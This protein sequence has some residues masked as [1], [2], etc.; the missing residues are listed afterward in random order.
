MLIDEFWTYEGGNAKDIDA[1][2]KRA[3][4][5][6]ANNDYDSEIESI[7]IM[8]Q[9]G[10]VSYKTNYFET[11][12]KM[13]M[14]AF[15]LLKEAKN[16]TLSYVEITVLAKLNEYAPTFEVLK[17][18]EKIV[19]ELLETRYKHEEKHNNV[20]WMVSG[21]ILPRLIKAKFS[22]DNI[23][24]AEGKLSE[25]N[26]MFKRHLAVNKHVFAKNPH[27]DP[28]YE[29]FVKL[30]EGIFYLNA[31]LIDESMEWFR[32]NERKTW[33]PHAEDELIMYYSLL[34]DDITKSQLDIVTGHLVKTLREAKGIAKEDVEKYTG[35]S[36]ELISLK[37][38]GKRGFTRTDL[39]KLASFF[40]VDISYFYYGNKEKPVYDEDEELE[41]LL[42][43]I[44]EMLKDAPDKTRDIVV[45]MVK[46]LTEL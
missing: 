42:N 20:K 41:N 17:T 11:C 19:L 31:N 32:Q 29:A 30:W 43:Q 7:L 4:Y 36:E 28:R 44:R 6:L 13:A 5:Y 21:N 46:K 15:D 10:K 23:R 24:K 35:I 1:R 18:C 45:D 27:L 37:E 38:T 33:Y 16:R 14:P 9:V 12:R 25:I 40:E 22:P 2:I 39:R 34:E 3:K 8:M 26:G